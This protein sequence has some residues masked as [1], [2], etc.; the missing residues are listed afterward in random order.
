MRYRVNVLLAVAS[1]T[2]AAARTEAAEIPTVFD[3]VDAVEVGG[4]GGG[5]RVIVT[6][7]Q[8]GESTP[9]TIEF[10]FFNNTDTA[11][12]CHRLAVLAMSKPG[13]FQFAIFTRSGGSLDG[14]CKL[15]RR[16][17]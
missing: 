15:I 1:L 3:T 7:V 14:G 4:T 12:H 8:T 16:T 5:P 6:G 10:T 17:P 9:T 2:F 13:R 11:S